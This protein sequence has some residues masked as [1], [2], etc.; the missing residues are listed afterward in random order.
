MKDYCNINPTWYCSPLSPNCPCGFNL[1]YVIFIIPEMAQGG[2]QRVMIQPMPPTPIPAQRNATIFF[3]M[4][5]LSGLIGK[6]TYRHAVCE[7][8]LY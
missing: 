7:E 5:N 3:A 4:C 1:G 8:I 6:L 2:N